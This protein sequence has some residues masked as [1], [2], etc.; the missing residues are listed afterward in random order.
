MGKS[1]HGT[2]STGLPAMLEPGNAA[3]LLALPILVC[4]SLLAG[5]QGD[6]PSAG[7]EALATAAA[8]VDRCDLLGPST[9]VRY[10]TRAENHSQHEVQLLNGTTDQ[11]SLGACI[12]TP[13]LASVVTLRYRIVD[14]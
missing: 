10:R 11:A 9:V 5:C 4:A 8:P 7:A 6:D 1:Q 13:P 14:G 2:R 3:R 12:G